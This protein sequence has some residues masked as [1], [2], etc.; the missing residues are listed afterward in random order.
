MI[1]LINDSLNNEYSDQCR[2][3]SEV[4]S[5]QMKRYN[6]SIQTSKPFVYNNNQNSEGWN[7]QSSFIFC[8][9]LNHTRNISMQGEFIYPKEVTM[10]REEYSQFINNSQEVC[11]GLMSNQENNKSNQ[12]NYEDMDSKF[13]TP[14][15]NDASYRTQAKKK[16]IESHQSIQSSQTPSC[17]NRTKIL[18]PSGRKR[19]QYSLLAKRNSVSQIL[20]HIRQYESKNR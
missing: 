13:N 18:N 8:P 17:A 1:Q 2:Y 4:S 19:S 6:D 3:N 7:T 12:E 9:T 5:T 10:S 15:F 16:I 14:W 20:A 11:L